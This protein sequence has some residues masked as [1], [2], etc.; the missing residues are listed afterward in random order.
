MIKI[1]VL[2]YDPQEDEEP[3]FETYS[4]KEQDKMKVLD[5][6]NY[7]NHEHH[8]HLAYRSSCRAGQCGSCAL[9]VNGEVVLACKAEIKDGDVL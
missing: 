8:A 5:A 1:K 2:R 9:K 7:I 4:L 6:L 3:Y